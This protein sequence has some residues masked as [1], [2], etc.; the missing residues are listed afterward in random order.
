LRA[1][2]LAIEGPLP[3][4]TLFHEAAR[5]R[6]DAVLC[7]YHDQ[8]LIPLKTLDF[9]RGVNVTLGLPIIRTSPD[10]GTAF[11]IAGTG[12]ADPASLIEA[13][14]LA[15]MLARNR[16][17]AGGAQ[18][19]P[20]R[21]APGARRRRRQTKSWAFRAQGRPVS[22][23]LGPPLREV[24]AA[25]GLDAKK[26]LGQHFLLDLN[27]T[28]RI[29]RAAAPLDDATIIEIG[30]GPG[31]LTRALLL[32]GAKHVIAVERDRRCIA[33]LQELAAL[34]PGRLTIIEADALT[35]DERALA[36]E[37]PVKI[38]A[39]LPY[40]ISTALLVKWLT[41]DPWPPWYESLTLMFQKEV[42]ERL[43]AEP[44]TKAYGRLSL[45]TQWRTEARRLFDI[46]PRAFVPPPQVTSTV[47]SLAPRAQPEAAPPLLFEKVVAAAFNQRRKMLRAS[48][49]R[50]GLTDA[51]IAEAGI[52]PTARAEELDVAGFARLARLLALTVR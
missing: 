45:L 24:I 31:G 38:V 52:A 49:S 4:D 43:I 17:G 2:G 30:P 18:Q 8:A 12:K 36:P 51:M 35:V 22:E 50:L 48:L 37:G 41:A 23:T 29:A 34:A 46:D 47:V 27:L 19:K 14:L 16:T 32:E 39:N 10:H 26:G 11:D 42:A 44:R 28:R 7:M 33:A 5:T 25:H 20:G 21:S 40:N 1:Q 3:A 9:A 13:I 15:D 6:F